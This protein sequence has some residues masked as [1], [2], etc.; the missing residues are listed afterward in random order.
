MSL[1]KKLLLF[2]GIIYAGSVV[3]FVGTENGR[4]AERWDAEHRGQEFMWLKLSQE[5]IVRDGYL[6]GLRK[7]REEK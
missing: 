6:W 2:L 7:I 1:W 5:A 4:D 3:Y